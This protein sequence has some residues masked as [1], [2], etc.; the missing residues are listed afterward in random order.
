MEVIVVMSLS[1]RK[2]RKISLHRQNTTTEYSSQDTLRENTVTKNTVYNS[3]A[4]VFCAPLMTGYLGY[5]QSSSMLFSF[6]LVPF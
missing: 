2:R 1:H 3:S 6:P 5:F 4:T